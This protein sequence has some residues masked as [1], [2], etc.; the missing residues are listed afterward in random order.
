[1]N[2]KKAAIAVASISLA[3]AAAWWFLRGD[4]DEEKIKRL[5]ARME[6]I[7]DK[8]SDESPLT[9]AAKNS[10]LS[11]LVADPCSLEVKEALI[12]GT[13]RPLEFASRISQGRVMF[14]E[15]HGK[16]EDLEIKI[17]TDGNTATA[18]YSV[19]VYGETKSGGK[20]DESRDLRS[21]LKKVDGEWKFASFAIDQALER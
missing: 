3:G 13:F 5:F 21:T 12:D 1:M 19:R 11:N 16:V 6:E 10:D 2:L 14:K 17:A 8:R 9:I 15:L 4:G 18:E 20:F 7:C